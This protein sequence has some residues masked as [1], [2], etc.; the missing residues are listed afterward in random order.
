MNIRFLSPRLHGLLD[1][2]AAAGLILLPFALNLDS[3]SPLALWLSVAGGV[4]LIVYSLLTD[5]SFGLVR[6]LPFQVHIAL[7]LAAAGAFMAAPSLFGWHGLTAGYY[8]IMATGVIVVVGL[9][10]A[11]DPALRAEQ[12]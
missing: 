12:V 11:A 3:T 6:V 10:G 7:D 8:Y 2:A 9:T 5:Y 4:G 1:Y